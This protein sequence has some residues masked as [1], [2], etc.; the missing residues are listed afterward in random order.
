MVEFNPEQSAHSG[1][2]LLSWDVTPAGWVEVAALWPALKLH[3]LNTEAWRWAPDSVTAAL[4][5]V[6]RVLGHAPVGTGCI[7]AA[8]S[9]ITKR[10]LAQV[11]SEAKDAAVRLLVEFA[12]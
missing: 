9:D 10:R 8:A 2:F 3:L 5:A 4:V 1:A 12:Q 11:R 6:L 7:A